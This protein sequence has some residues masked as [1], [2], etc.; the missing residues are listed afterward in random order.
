MSKTGQGGPV[1]EPPAILFGSFDLP[2][3][4]RFDWHTHDAHQVLWAFR[5]VLSVSTAEGTWVLPPTKAL[6]VPAGVRHTTGAADRVEMHSLYV[7]AA[8][9]PVSWSAPTVFV[10]APLLRE[11]LGHLATA[12]LTA[13]A[14]ARAE[15]V[16]FDL[17]DPVEV[18]AIRVPLPSE[19]RAHRV[20]EA[21]L[22]D[23]T[24]GCTLEAWGR[25]VGASGRTLA[26]LFLAETGMSFGRWRTHARLR[27]ALPLLASGATVAAVARQVGYATPSGFVAAFRQTV[28]IPPA[29]YF[30]QAP[31]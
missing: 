27:A 1:A 3:G 16:L 6:W 14:R 15:A 30:G 12:D 22:A 10:V 13:D 23:P 8:G 29:T 21:L 4:L 19:A 24:D 26:R 18:S 31:S 7:D 25:V 20:A 5:G 9:C 11:L 17:L 28:G 2:R